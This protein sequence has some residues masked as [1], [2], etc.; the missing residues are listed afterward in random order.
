MG[1]MQI[2][3]FALAFVIALAACGSRAS[4]APVDTGIDGTAGAACTGAVYDPCTDNS[5][6]L[7]GQ[8]HAYNG[9]GIQVCTQACNP[10]AC[11]NDTAGLAVAC[12][13]MNN[14]KPSVANNC[15]R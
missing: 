1:L 8:C 5:Q 14:C 7:S 13:T 15:H 9:A 4:P 12:N 3:R 10:A 6:C 11:P 2:T